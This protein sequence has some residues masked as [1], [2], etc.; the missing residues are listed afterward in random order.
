MTK[1][2]VNKAAI[3]KL[4][5]FVI[6]PIILVLV[7]FYLRR[8][9]FFGNNFI[10]KTLLKED[11]EFKHFIWAEF[12]SRKGSKDTGETYYKNGSYYL[13]NSGKDN[14]NLDTALMLDAARHK[15]E[16]TWN[17]ANPMNRISFVFSSA[18]R[19]DSRNEE[20]GGVPKSA[21]RNKDGKKAHAVDIK[22]SKYSQE[23]KNII[24]AALRE[25]GFTRFG[26][27]NSFLHVDN[28]LTLPNP[29]NWV[30]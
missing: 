17:V 13:T 12:D 26:K 28:D 8:N 6:L 9:Y 21:H 1:V 14:F 15:I 29:A 7:V 2:T 30:Y 19:T 18:Y 23:Q 3:I 22:W 25:Q 10:N 4:T 27:A 16:Q 20:I 5:V 11:M 24:E